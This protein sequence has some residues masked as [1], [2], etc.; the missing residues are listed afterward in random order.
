MS[1]VFSPVDRFMCSAWGN[2]R[3]RHVLGK[4][5]LEG[6]EA[7]VVSCYGLMFTY[8]LDKRLELIIKNRLPFV[9]M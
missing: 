9:C 3:E 2:R 1:A 5:V 6:R 7:V 8:I 4:R